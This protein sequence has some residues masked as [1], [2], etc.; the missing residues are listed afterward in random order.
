MS[1]YQLIRIALSLSLLFAV[2]CRSDSIALSPLPGSVR[3]SAFRTPDKVVKV[4]KGEDL[5]NIVN[6]AYFSQ[7]WPTALAYDV[8]GPDYLSAM[9]WDD[10]LRVEAYTESRSGL[11][12]IGSLNTCPE[13]PTRGLNNCGFVSVDWPIWVTNVTV[14]LVMPTA[15]DFLNKTT[16]WTVL[17]KVESDASAEAIWLNLKRNSTNW[18]CMG[19]LWVSECP[20][21]YDRLAQHLENWRDLR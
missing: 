2:S 11:I 21:L 3:H 7:L 4:P 5:T 18:D 8:L 13:H 12:L 15:L 14:D 1:L 20:V 19:L 6:R 9:W 10:N 17:V 16:N